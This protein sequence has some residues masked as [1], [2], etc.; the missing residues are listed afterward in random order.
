MGTG[1]KTLPHRRRGAAGEGTKRRGGG[2]LDMGNRKWR[3]QA[4]AGANNRTQG[5]AARLL[6]RASL[7]PRALDKGRG[8]NFGNAAVVVLELAGEEFDG[9][10]PDGLVVLAHAGGLAGK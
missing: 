2:G 3:A 4:S 10:A 1:A 7:E 5:A 9:H 8:G 6:Q